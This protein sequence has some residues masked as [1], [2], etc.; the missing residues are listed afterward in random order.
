MID[1]GRVEELRAEIGD[2]DFH[3]VV[4]MFLEEADEVIVQISGPP[5]PSQL[6]SRLHFLKG[7]ALNL[8]LTELAGLCQDGE[9][10]AATGT[11]TSVDL[12][13]V[14][15]IYRASRLQITQS[16]GSAAA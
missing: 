11:A 4:A 6:E 16:L 14:V 5:D 10:H 9:R 13:A 15:A 1:W 3:E 2:D 12:A 7:S 8:G